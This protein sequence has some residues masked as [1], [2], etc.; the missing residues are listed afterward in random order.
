[1]SATW[2]RD[3]ASL[4]ALADSL[5]AGPALALDSESD[6]LHHHVEKVCLLQL[7]G[8]DGRVALV[9]T[10]A[11]RDLSPLAP[12]LADPGLV[13]VLHGADYDVTTLKRDF[14][15]EFTS[16][17]DTMIAARFLGKAQ[18][19]LQAIAASE[20]GV[21]LS[22]DSQTDDWSRRPLTP[23][24][25]AYAADDVR[26]L[27]VLRERLEAGLATAGRLA[28]VREECAAVAALPAAERRRDP[29]AFLRLK[30]A[31]KLARRSLAV[32]RE[33]W[34]WREAQAE[35]SNIP[36]FKLVSTEALLELAQSPPASEAELRA[37]R[38]LSPRLRPRLGSLFEALRRGQALP[39]EQWPEV[40]RAPRPVVPPEVQA[41]VQRLRAWRQEEGARQALDISLVLPQRLID[42]LAE[43]APRTLDDLRRVE[44]LRQWRCDTW[45]EA[46][47]KLCR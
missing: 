6:S 35:E 15:F 44:G 23:R 34:G 45:G 47:L 19:G 17:F 7:C 22:K 43:A 40:P 30:G 31:T 32:L 4:A 24:Q 46:L 8:P 12:L 20:L 9:D 10:L 1:M 13:K 3:A 5:R 39:P 2:I 29:Q 14:G 28:W 37:R 18:F 42:K 16:L 41:R 21:A 33:A 11:L 26:H 27:L 25:E 38:G 36:S